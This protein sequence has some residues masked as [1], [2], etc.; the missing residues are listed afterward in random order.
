MRIQSSE[1]KPEHT[2]A[3]PHPNICARIYCTQ[4]GI[5]IGMKLYDVAVAIVGCHLPSG[6]G[7]LTQGTEIGH[8]L[9]RGVRDWPPPGF[10]CG[11]CL[12]STMST[13]KLIHGL[14]LEIFPEHSAD[15]LRCCLVHSGSKKLK[16][17]NQGLNYILDN[18]VRRADTYLAHKDTKAHAI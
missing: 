11:L 7:T 5:A 12:L 6:R 18:T 17:R 13:I 14:T 8:P 16:A 1:T 4:A 9:G 3:H 15:P 2:H 10:T